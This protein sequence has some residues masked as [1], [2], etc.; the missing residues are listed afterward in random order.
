MLHL[1]GLEGGGI[2]T[3]QH[4]AGGRL[5]TTRL[6]GRLRGRDLLG[7]QQRPQL[8]YCLLALRTEARAEA[9]RSNLR[10]AWRQPLCM[11]CCPLRRRPPLRR[12]RHE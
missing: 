7:C 6:R 2:G 1:R 3:G 12:S 11:R 4:R 10:H 5:S 9:A 8:R